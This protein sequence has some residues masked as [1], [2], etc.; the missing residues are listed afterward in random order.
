MT[1]WKAAD[2]YLQVDR[3]VGE[4]NWITPGTKNGLIGLSNFCQKR[5]KLFSEKRNDPNVGALSNLSPWLHFGIPYN[6]LNPLQFKI[7]FTVKF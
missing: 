6:C 2:A 5:L 1:D 7:M 3:S 4:V